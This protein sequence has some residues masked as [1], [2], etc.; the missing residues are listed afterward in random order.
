M[1]DSEDP[2]ERDSLKTVLHRIY[3]KFLHFRT[4][5]RQMMNNIF[6]RFCAVFVFIIL[7][8]FTQE[9]E[10][11]CGISELL[12]IYGSIINGFAL[13]LKEEHKKFLI[14]VLLPLHKVSSVNTYH[15]QVFPFFYFLYC[16]LV[17]LLCFT[18]H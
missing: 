4:T 10:R 7:F 15:G 17:E 5:I 3:G 2:R 11:F 1:F 14:N 18:I 12:E 8:R 13:P 6:I 16:D 9:T